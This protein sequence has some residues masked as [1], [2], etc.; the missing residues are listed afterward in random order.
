[1]KRTGL[2]ADGSDASHASS[3]APTAMTMHRGSPGIEM[4]AKSGFSTNANEE[5]LVLMRQQNELLLDI[6]NT[7]KAQNEFLRNKV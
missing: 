6:A 3:D 1:M 7:L 5:T 4:R 2:L